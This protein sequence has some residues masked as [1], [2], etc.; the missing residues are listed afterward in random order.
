MTQPAQH[1][2]PRCQTQL[3][4]E[5]IEEPLAAFDSLSCPECR[6]RLLSNVQLRMIEETVE[7]RLI[8]IRRISHRAEQDLVLHCPRCPNQPAMEKYEHHRDKRVLLDRCGECDSI[9][10]D[11][12]EL[13]AIRDE[14][15]PVFV[16]NTV[17]YFVELFR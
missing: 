4:P 5:R 10:L 17:R 7:P 11:A 15:L 12:G 6:G 8:E 14:S 1:H 3:A 16:V 13:K 9:W 2:C